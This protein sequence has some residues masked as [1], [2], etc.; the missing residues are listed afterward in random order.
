M[1][2]ILNAVS[3]TISGIAKRLKWLY[4]LSKA[5]VGKNSRIAFPFAVEGL[6]KIKIGDDAIIERRAEL[7]C[8]EQCEITFQNNLQL[9]ENTKITVAN[10]SVS[11]FGRGF[12]LLHGAHCYIHGNWQIAD[13]VVIGSYCQ[14]FSREKGFYGTLKIGEGSHIGDFTLVDVCADI[15]IGANVAIG[16]R[17]TIY[18]H[19]HDYTVNQDIPWHGTPKTKPVVIMDGAWVGSNVT[20]LPGVVIG[21]GSIIAAGSIVTRNVEPHTLVA[22]VPAKTIRQLKNA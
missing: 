12:S 9:A 20:I 1:S 3:S 7:A 2:I 8:A 4:R 17:C 11:V 6:G 16:P 10:K 13:N 14:V 5:T 22:G 15:T 19:D 18:T 21:R